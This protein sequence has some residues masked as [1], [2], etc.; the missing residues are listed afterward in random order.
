MNEVTLLQFGLQ[1]AKI[2][3][4]VAVSTAAAPALFFGFMLLWGLKWRS[5]YRDVTAFYIAGWL[6]VLIFLLIWTKPWSGASREGLRKGA[7]EGLVT[8]RMAHRD[9]E[10]RVS[11]IQF[12]D[13]FAVSWAATIQNFAQYS[14]A[15][16]AMGVPIT[17][18][19]ACSNVFFSHLAGVTPGG[20]KRIYGISSR[21]L[22]IAWA[23]MLPYYL[24]LDM[25]VRHF[26][27]KYT[28]SL[29]YARVMLLGI[30]FFAAIQ[31]LQMSY[32]YLS[33]TQRQF[34]V[35]TLVVLAVSFGITSFVAFHCASLQVV[36]VVQV[37]ILAGWWL[38][39]EW[40]LR[41]LTGERIAGWGK[42]LGAYALVS[43]IYCISTLPTHVRATYSIPIYYVCVALALAAIFNG[44]LRLYLG[45][46]PSRQAKC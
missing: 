10:H 25:F 31:I 11:L 33:G 46:I 1:D 8:D 42:F 32:A 6:I 9:G 22:L 3:G 29:Q 41:D 45:L 17:A 28:A 2:F 35:R 5:D 7:G 30:P 24:A 44:D 13:R 26:L 21:A 37:G 39:N 19:Q 20:R 15:A 43:V 36:A 38:F 14:L 12:A 34:L 4:P 16:S 23:V 40:T 18:I 27:P